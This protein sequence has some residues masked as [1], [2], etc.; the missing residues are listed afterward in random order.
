MIIRRYQASDCEE[1]AE[2]FYDTVHC[3]NAG[4]NS[5]MSGRRENWIWHS[6]ICHFENITVLLQLRMK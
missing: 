3:V 1:T 4:K 5:W 2:L 6:G